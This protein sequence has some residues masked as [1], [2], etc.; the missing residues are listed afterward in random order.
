MNY[1]HFPSLSHRWSSMANPNERMNYITEFVYSIYVDHRELAFQ[2][3]R[4]LFVYSFLL[5]ICVV[6]FLYHLNKLRK[7]VTKVILPDETKPRFR[8]RDKVMFFG[9]KILRKVRSSVP[10]PIRHH[11]GR[12]RQLV[13]K[14]AKRLLQ[15]KKDDPLELK[16]KEPSQAFLKEE[17]IYDPSGHDLPE[18]LVYMIHGIR[19]L[20]FFEKPLFLKMCQKIEEIKVMKGEF[21]FNIG[22]SD[23]SIYIVRS[24]EIKVTLNEPD[25][26]I[27]L[28]KNVYAGEC[29]ASMLSVMDILNGYPSQFKTV[30]ASA[31]QDSEILRLKINVLK[32]LVDDNPEMLIR[33]VQIIMV[34]LQ[35]VTFTSL[36]KYLGLTTQLIK[37][38]IQLPKRSLANINAT[39]LKK[40]SP[41]RNNGRIS[42]HHRS[43]SNAD[44]I[45]L[46]KLI[47]MESGHNELPSSPKLSRQDS[48]DR[49]RSSA[50][51]RKKSV[52]GD[53]RTAGM[54]YDELVDMAIADLKIILNI[55]DGDILRDN[56]RIKE[57]YRDACLASE[58][59]HDEVNLI[60]VLSGSIT[61]SNK[62]IDS[63][64]EANLYTVYPGELIGALDV[65]SGEESIFTVR[66]KQNCKVAVI[67]RD[68]AYDILSK[69]P[70]V[71]LNLAHTVIQRLSPFVRQ[72]DFALD[73]NHYESGRAIYRIGE[74]SDC[75]Y[76]VL[77]GR[78]RS[79]ITLTNG[80]RQLVGEYGKGD[81]VGIVEL[82]TRTPRSLTV[83]AVRDTE[84]AKLPDG[85]LETIKT[86]YPVVVTRLIHLLG[87][88]L[89]VGN[90][91]LC[92]FSNV[93][94]I[95]D[96]GSR[97]SGSNFST[98]ALLSVTD[99]VPLHAFGYELYHAL[100]AI[101]SVQLL[102][103]DFVRK[104]LG[105]SALD[106]QSEYRLCHW[107][108]I[109]EDKNKIVLYQCDKGY[110]AWTQRCIRQADCILIV[111]MAEQEPTVGEV[112]K[113]LQYLSIRTQKE[114]V[115]LHRLDGPK[116]KN[117]VEWLNMR[118]WCSSHHHIRCPKRVFIKRSPLKLREY[119]ENEL[120]THQPSIF[121]DF[122][123][124][125]RFL[126]GKSIGLVLGGG[127]AR[128][129]AHIGM[130]KAITEAGLPIDMVGGVSIGAFMGALWCQENNLTAFIQ[131][132]QSWSNG[133][134][135]YWHQILDL[136]YPSTAMFTGNAFNRSIH[137]V[138]GEVQIEDLWLPYFT[139]TTDI[140]SS[141]PRTHRHGSLWR[142]V[143]ASMS[144]SGYLPPLCDPID[145]HLLLDGGYVNNL[146][147][148]IMHDVMGAEIILAIDV[149][150]QDNSDLTNYG[151]TLSG[152]WLLWKRWNPFTEPVRVPNLPEIQSRLAYVCCE[153]QLEEVK[154]S[155]YC[156]YIRPPI[157]G[158]KTLQFKSFKEIMNVGY[159]H[160]K[161]V[162][163]TVHFG[164]ERSIFEL[165]NKERN[166]IR[167]KS[168][169][170]NNEFIAGGDQS[171][172]DRSLMMIG[173]SPRQTSFTDL[174]ERICNIQNPIVSNSA[175]EFEFHDITEDEAE[176]EAD[177][178]E[179]E[180]V[181]DNY[182]SEPELR[183][184]DTDIENL[185]DRKISNEV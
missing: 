69:Y 63:N 84:L 77:S 111:G 155:D 60:F 183:D 129:I 1:L 90:N 53:D 168:I 26:S 4:T 153:K 67:S 15:L 2:N 41:S 147:A 64:E 50:M 95:S 139:V 5:A 131:K 175:T 179:E 82:I 30:S 109:Q 143:R 23:D 43:Y 104:C 130:I 176:A 8:K 102:T 96:I 45:D 46:G 71:A 150:S 57:F 65:L 94:P 34:R 91:N 54:T 11:R 24:G 138:F 49:S 165:F 152:W 126:T 181:M 116:P 125:A 142:Y 21:L 146:P 18:E 163:S 70:K 173:K 115:L 106:R 161:A 156:W 40:S 136:T 118:D 180:E 47:R 83:I 20:G 29:I 101:G 81:L 93:K 148:D 178:E 151:D 37:P 184:T 159:H 58:E 174:A 62:L 164:D 114:L 61:I 162:F 72:I 42:G 86:K 87:H 140:T 127:G 110:S 160:G 51:K 177:E 171:S 113:Q 88:R 22:D 141:C 66:T 73:W 124:L 44:A 28:L 132:A 112:E 75:T 78:L 9:R 6:I 79:V 117:T 134:I 39:L 108:G 48:E 172:I 154:N 135:S 13:L 14:F 133:M 33:V 107:L 25:G 170:S 16:V 169:I 80:K 157:D 19:V 35:R 100:T 17:D 123:R 31:I 122:S 52:L 74:K 68:G 119:Y 3:P 7:K 56:I 185:I 27:L 12:K 158:F 38:G 103:S 121:S 92:S 120:K 137:E 59:C 89:L 10:D 97:P 149:G 166:Q 182:F 76:I 128:G 85:L 99:E 55:D 105:P 145:G 167:R 36:Y 98:V 144:L 32:Q